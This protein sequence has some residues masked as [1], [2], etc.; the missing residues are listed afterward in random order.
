VVV[1]AKATRSAVEELSK[2]LRQKDRKP[3]KPAPEKAAPEEP[4]PAQELALAQA[5]APE[6][7]QSSERLLPED[8]CGKCLQASGLNP[9]HSLGKNVSEERS[10]TT[11][12]RS[13]S[14]EPA[15]YA[16]TLPVTKESK[17]HDKRLWLSLPRM[18]LKDVLD[19]DFP[20]K[21]I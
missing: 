12:Q 10:S 1:P 4:A 9:E 14:T 18:R 13:S 8:R 2:P 5:P 21:P 3:K 11:V 15:S 7:E 6:P 19:G 17:P 16:A 20:S